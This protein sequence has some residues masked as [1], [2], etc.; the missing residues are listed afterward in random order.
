MRNW[1][2]RITG[3]SGAASLA[4]KQWESLTEQNKVQRDR[5]GHQMSL[6]FTCVPA[7]IITYAI[8]IQAHTTHTLHTLNKTINNVYKTITDFILTDYKDVKEKFFLE[9]PVPLS[10]TMKSLSAC[11]PADTR[12]PDRLRS[13]SHSHTWLC[14]AGT[15]V[16]G[17]ELVTIYCLCSRMIPFAPH[18]NHTNSTDWTR[19]FVGTLSCS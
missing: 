6:A 7:H 14:L 8:Y 3:A 4:P 17:V 9:I 10:F 1:C 12:H 11:R 15:G 18:W 13:A 19:D 16:G 5:T 2:R